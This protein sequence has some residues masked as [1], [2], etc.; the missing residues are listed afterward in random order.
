MQNKSRLALQ[1]LIKFVAGLLLL[2][3][4][5]FLP[6][7][8]V[9]YFGA[10]LFLGVLF[11]PMLIMGIVMLIKAPALLEKR[12][13]GKEKE[14][15]QKGVLALSGLIF[16]AGFLLSALDFRFGWSHVPLWVVIVASVLFLIGYATYAEVMREN[17]YLSRTVEV[18]KGQRVISTG[19]YGVVRHPMYLATLLMFLPIPLILGSFWGLVP[20]LLYP[21]ILVIRILNEEQVLTEGLAGYAEYKNKVKYRLIPFVW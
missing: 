13:N 10:W 2:G 5:L 19:L 4:A 14:S 3:A 9:R 18:Q 12:L 1:G 7:W 11:I 15:A 21:V 8:T 17:T 6:A 20:M 16:P